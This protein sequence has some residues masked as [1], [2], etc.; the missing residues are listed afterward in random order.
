V[1]Q[2]GADRIGANATKCFSLL[3]GRNTSVAARRSASSDDVYR[4]LFLKKGRW[5]GRD[6]GQC[7]LQVEAAIVD[8]MR[9]IRRPGERY[10]HVI[11]RL[12]DLETSDLK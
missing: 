1:A 12:V 7:F 9:A 5:G 6:R 3:P 8:R 10:S 4:R 2:F 11:L